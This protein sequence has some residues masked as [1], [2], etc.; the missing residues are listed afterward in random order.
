MKYFTSMFF[1]N[2]NGATCST[3]AIQSTYDLEHCAGNC[4]WA[5]M[6]ALVTGNLNSD[7]ALICPPLRGFIRCFYELPLY[8]F[9]S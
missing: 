9:S 5:Q 3:W 8:I 7:T 1:V 6:S 4:S 2:V